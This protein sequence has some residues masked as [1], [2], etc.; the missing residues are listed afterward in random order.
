MCQNSKA[1]LSAQKERQDM[2]ATFGKEM[3]RMI[4]ILVIKPSE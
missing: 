1:A 4:S 2:A 3:Q